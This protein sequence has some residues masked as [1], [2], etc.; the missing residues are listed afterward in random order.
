MLKLEIMAVLE[1][2]EEFVAA[3]LYALPDDV[4]W[5]AVCADGENDPEPSAL[6]AA[7]PGR[8]LY[9]L[10]VADVP[11]A[12]RARLLAAA[13][14]TYDL[15]EL[16]ADRDLTDEILAAVPGEKRLISVYREGGTQQDLTADFARISSVPARYYKLESVAH[17][18]SEAVAP[19]A[20]LASLGRNDVV[21]FAAGRAGAW[22]RVVAP[23]LG[24]P[25]VVGS[26]TSRRLAEGF[27]SVEELICDYGFPATRRLEE[28][29]GIVGNP[30]LHSL[31]PLLHNASHRALDRGALFVPF[32]AESFD[33]FWQAF[34]VREVLSALGIRLRGLTVASPH[35]ERALSVV[36]HATDAASRAGA[37]NA[38]VWDNGRRWRA[39]TTDPGG[40]FDL[41][42]EHGIVPRG[43]RIAIVGAGGSGR[44]I[45][46]ALD[47]AGNEVVVVN[48]G[49]QRAELTRALLGLPVVRLS[50]FDPGGYSVLI[51][52]TPVGKNGVDMPFS[53]DDLHPDAVVIDLPYGAGSTPLI[54][55]ARESGRLAIDG[56]QMLLA[57]VPR[58]FELMTG[59][60]MPDGVAEAA[61][62]QK[63]EQRSLPSRFVT[64]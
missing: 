23:F 36:G 51:N 25:L 59:T 4:S 24:S 43:K 11:A 37:A 8:L 58:Q 9:S 10:P 30:A 7:F 62:A 34:A 6:R 61:L 40:V 3:R 21:A 2:A 29:Y 53:V 15:V 64:C 41:L 46:A 17:R 16:H 19:L 42:H 50:A 45:A 12:R 13:A 52:A 60:P 56:R 54:V 26:M 47:D 38:L 63:R 28:I 55:A 31:S 1:P 18:P 33:D 32:H 22:S 35:K 27:F 48:R 5:L 20:L 14:T 44:A 39:E 49:A 57:Q